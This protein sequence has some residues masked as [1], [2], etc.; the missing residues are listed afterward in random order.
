MKRLVIGLVL[1][2]A[3]TIRGELIGPSV[4]L[5]QTKA[6]QKKPKDA[7]PTKD[8]KAAGATIELYKDAGGEFR[9]R[10]KDSEGT[11]IAIAPRGHEKKEDCEK[12]IATLRAQLATAKLD[13]KTK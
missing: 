11:I 7:P 5:A 6:V 2:V 8:T 4:A 1:L 3:V 10:I 12:A 13:D 9:F